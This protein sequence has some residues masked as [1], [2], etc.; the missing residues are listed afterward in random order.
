MSMMMIVVKIETEIGI[1]IRVG[2]VAVVIVIVVIIVII[3]VIVITGSAVTVPIFVAVVPAIALSA[4][5]A[6]NLLDKRFRLV[7]YCLHFGRDEGGSKARLRR[8]TKHSADRCC[9]ENVL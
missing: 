8:N 5:P 3:I 9:S 7:R 4:V 1:W 6:M 2:V